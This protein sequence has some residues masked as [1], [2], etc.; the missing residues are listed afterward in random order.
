MKIKTKLS[1]VIFL[2][3]AVVA[4]SALVL[5]VP[6]GPSIKAGATTR[7]NS[8]LDNTTGG[9]NEQAQAGNLTRLTIN[10]TSVTNRWQGYYGNVTTQIT[11]DD[12]NNYTLYD[13]ASASPRGEVYA[14]NGSANGAV[15]W[16]SVFCFNYTNNLSDEVPSN[17]QKFNGTDL[18]QTLGSNIYDKD[19]VNTTFNS[20]Y[21][22]TFQVGSITINGASGCRK[23]DL[24]SNDL[25]QQSLFQEVLLTDNDSIIY[26]S[27]INQDQTGFQG[28]PV[29]FEMLVG[30]NGDLPAATLY[31][32]FV[33]LS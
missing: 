1:S 2:I 19:S 3:F 21:S 13:W 9:T 10:S 22:G 33:E 6:N 8:S 4:I 17:V 12:G 31:Y 26:T 28:A 11:L 27:I 32:F 25:Y 16:S 7:R 15:T 14:S 5:A 24:Y 30:E 20:T 18:E 29:D 23:A